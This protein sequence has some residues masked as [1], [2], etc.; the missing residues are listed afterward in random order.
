MS[1]GHPAWQDA[2][3]RA[4]IRSLQTLLVLAVVLVVTY[5]AIRLRLIV[6]P[7]LIATLVAAAVNPVVDWLDNR[8][9]PRSLATLA[10]ML[11]GFAVLGA[12]GW[13][14][15]R[16]VG[17][18]WN[19]MVDSAR[20]G[21]TELRGYVLDGPVPITEQN[22]QDAQEQ[23][24]EFVQ[25]SQFQQGAISGATLAIEIVAGLFLGL[26]LLFFLLRDGRRIWAFLRDQ[27][28]AQYRERWDITAERSVDVLGGY[29][30]GTAVVAF[31]D[32]LVIGI[33]L[34]IL[35][36]PLALP[37]AVVVFIGA[38][39]PLVGATVAGTLAA[40][41]ALVSNG[42]VTALIVVA[43]V[44]AVNQLEGDILAPIVLGQAL[45]LHPLAILL[46]LTAGT[47][48]A[49][50]IGALLSV[51]FAAVV[52]TAVKTLRQYRSGSPPGEEEPDEEPE[53]E[54]EPD[55][56]DAEPAAEAPAQ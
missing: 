24:G 23:L 8:K 45:S 28:P 27:L 33:A 49:G 26:V 16:A 3:G 1:V 31:V 30:R 10:T 12:V 44:I 56:G 39:I 22:L 9:V 5:A 17:D 42:F 35:G 36:V 46:A 40:L 4:A 18:Q 20:D 50:V 48:V 19:E 53:E 25:G 6:V 11:S 47:I 51:P 41:V 13:W 54:S 38:F 34:F 15:S 14:I 37:L 7:L 2:F 21:W 55:A 32:A 52:W 29:V 43:V